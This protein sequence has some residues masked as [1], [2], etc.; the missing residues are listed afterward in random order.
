M[1][2]KLVRT[3]VA[4]ALCGIVG[5]VAIYASW[6]FLTPYAEEYRTRREVAELERRVGELRAERARLQEQAEL[7]ATPEGIKREARRLGLL[8]PGERSLRFL[9]RPEPRTAPSQ[10]EPAPSGAPDRL[11]AR[12]RAPIPS[13]RPDD[14]G[15]PASE[16]HPQ[17][18]E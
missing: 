4:G 15:A 14:A 6:R 16:A 3:L 11:R 2:A 1:A 9:T 10:S 13:E 18:G 12:G 17:P 5:V 7:L 8:K